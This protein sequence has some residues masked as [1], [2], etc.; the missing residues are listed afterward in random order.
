LGGGYRVNVINGRVWLFQFWLGVGILLRPLACPGQQAETPEK[1][2]SEEAAPQPPADDKRTELNLL[3]KTEV[4]AGE[5]R[6]NENIQFNLIDNNALKELNSRL[7]TS[8]TVTSEFL[9]EFRYFGTEF[10]NKPSPPMRLDPVRQSRDFHGGIY[11]THDNSIFRAR[12]FFQVGGVK[13]AHENDYGFAAGLGLWHGAHLALTGSGQNVRGSVNGNVLVPL[14]SERTPL[15]TDPAAYRLIQKWLDAYPR[16]APNRTDFDPRA[17]NTNSPQSIDTD[18]STIRLDQDLGSR[19]HLFLRHA[20]TN[21]KVTAFE[22]VAGQNPDTNTK[23]HNARAT[24]NHVFDPK[25]FID[26]TVDFDRVH[27]LLVPEPNAVGPQVII[28]TSYQSLGPNASIPIDRRVNRFRYATLYR[29][30][31]GNHSFAAGAEWDRDQNNG[32]E[33]SSDRG[34]YYFRSDFGRD[35][36]T[37]FRLG[38]ASRYSIGLGEGNRGFRW[39]E[40]QYF[41]GDVWKVRSDFTLNAGLRYQPVTGPSEVNHLTE[42]PFDCD[43]NTVAPQFGFA[44]QLPS[45]GVIR[46]G[47]GLQYG[48]IYPQTLQQLRWDPP[49]FLK[50][51]VQAPTLLNPLAK[52]YVGPGARH[53]QF[54]VPRN[55]ESPYTHEYS[56]TWDPLPGRR[57]NIQVSYIGSRSHKLF[58]IWFMNRAVPVPGIPQTTATIT[59]RRPD[60]RYFELREAQN[61]SNAYF[62]AARIDLKAP[63]WHGLSLDAAYWFSKAI[64]TGSNYS[65]LAAGDDARQG[66][67][68]SQD[69]VAQDLKGPSV[70]DQSHAAI[71][72]FQYSIP[73][74]RN[75]LLRRAAG[76]WRISGV[77]LAK[78]GLPFTVISGS[79][80]PGFGNVD[81]T[82]G[83]R[84]NLLDPKILGRTI[85]N[86]ETSQSLLPRSAFSLIQPTDSRGNLGFNTFRRGGIR[87]MNAAL[88]RSWPLRSE[89]N[90][91]FRAESINFFNT[92]QFAE[93]SADLSSP[94]FGKITNTLNDGRSFQLTLQVQ[95]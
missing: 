8:A 1:P 86:P 30:Q 22:F 20:F 87:N 57:W 6:R 9:P 42:V 48:G 83:D 14:A 68:Q 7:G 27:S 18:A 66:Y 72:R 55:L 85:G 93:P 61:A 37:N 60:P 11:F 75:H 74:V 77:F 13:P 95:F 80:A 25:S 41:M 59:A 53:T 58:M 54:A 56:F 32:L 29:R 65:N 78:S 73:S 51:E 92:P 88:A 2:K 62:D 84:P 44:W 3:G 79:D 34:N 50:V 71:V 15:T 36:I 33:A 46:A 38:T 52:T 90:L 39:W 76:G 5:S 40:Q 21:Q 43:C 49:G 63:A 70:F 64:D 17:L 28:G 12:S 16:L 45:A 81:G 35:A 82:Y 47:Y 4:E 31:W 23:S 67:S 26:F 89:A 24:W 91:T 10:G 94:A 69:L 19:D